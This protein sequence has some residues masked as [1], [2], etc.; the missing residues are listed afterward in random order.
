MDFEP[1][2]QY[3]EQQRRC[4][5]FTVRAYRSD[6]K[7]FRSFLKSRS[8]TRLLQVSHLTINDYVEHLRSKANVR[9]GRTGLADASIA[10]RLAAI[11]SLFEYTRATT[12]F[13]LRN[14]IK[15][16][17]RKWQKDISPK[18]IDELALDLL[19][20]G[21]T[22][23]RD[24]FLFTLF[25]VTGLRVSEL[26]Q[27]NRNS[28]EIEEEVNLATGEGRVVGLGEVVGKGNK[29]RRFYVE[30]DALCLYAQYL[31]TRTDDEPAL[32]ISAQGRR[33]SVRAVQYLLQK[34][35]QRLGAPHLNVHRFRHSFATRL[36]NANIDSTHLKELMGHTSFTTTNRYF[37]LTD[38]TVARGYFAAM[39]FLRK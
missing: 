4:S 26:H 9:T 30:E 8:V 23:L 13:K 17:T 10:R 18:P 20:T 33:L 22:N 25:L 11:S 2:F 37:K 32:F 36:A 3:L 6:L 1:F 35:C 27:L 16:V 12:D 21:M 19:L 31:E 28:I 5:S 7:F 14:P 39:E 15:S 34:W 24:R 38:T 29:R